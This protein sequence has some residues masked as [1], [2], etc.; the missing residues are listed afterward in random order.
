MFLL[1]S[2]I[3]IFFP[4]IS[5][6]PAGFLGFTEISTPAFPKVLT[7]FLDFFFKHPAGFRSSQIHLLVS[8]L[9][10]SPSY[11]L[12]FH[13]FSRI[14]KG[15]DLFIEFPNVPKGFSNFCWLLRN[16]GWFQVLQMSKSFPGFSKISTSFW[17]SQIFPNGFWNS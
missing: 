11:F 17:D 4:V 10:R 2:V 16:P 8:E 9:L 1:V 5:R 7:G 15:I 3:H 13:I 12:A 6:I 14:L